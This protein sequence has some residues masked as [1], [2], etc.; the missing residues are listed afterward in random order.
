MKFKRLLVVMAAVFYTLAAGFLLFGENA[1]GRIAELRA[2]SVQEQE[3]TIM[4]ATVS[5]TVRMSEDTVKAE[6]PEP[7]EN[8]ESAVRFS[9]FERLMDEIIKD[10]APDD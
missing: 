2:Q 6:V 9:N 1:K 3:E 4:T 7:E 10:T 5:D 8:I